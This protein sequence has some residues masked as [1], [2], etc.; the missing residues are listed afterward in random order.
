[1]RERRAWD[2]A[3]DRAGPVD[4]HLYPDVITVAG[5]GHRNLAVPVVGH[6]RC[7]GKVYLRLG[8]G[9]DTDLTSGVCIA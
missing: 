8:A 9:R 2:Q 4:V 1:M 6:S 7:E 5:P 3:G